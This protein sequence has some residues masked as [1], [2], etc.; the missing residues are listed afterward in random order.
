MGKEVTHAV[1]FRDP[2]QPTIGPDREIFLLACD[3]GSLY[4]FQKMTDDRIWT[5]RS[6]GSTKEPRH[7]WSQS[8]AP[9]PGDVTDTLDETLGKKLWTK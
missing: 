9:L 8:R 3:D 1:K 6:R 4:E 5:M 2:R 7:S